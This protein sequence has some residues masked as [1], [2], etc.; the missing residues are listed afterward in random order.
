M[1]TNQLSH[2]DSSGKAKMVDVSGKQITRRSATAAGEVK[3]SPTTF[4]ILTREV[5]KKG[6]LLTVSKLVGIM[7]AKKTAELIPLCHPLKITKIDVDLAYDQELPGI[8]VR[9]TVVA[10]DITGVEME[11]L[12]AVSVAC[13]TVYDMA[14]AVDKNM[15][16]QNIRLIEK[17]GGKC[18]P[19]K[20]ETDRK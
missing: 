14:K 12:T 7:A 15:V 16:I 10:E 3:V 5:N 13:L 20:S 2:I 9:S 18:G 8:R 11:A 19:F 17:S 4:D 6:D 1:K